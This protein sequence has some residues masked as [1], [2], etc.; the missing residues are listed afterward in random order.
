MTGHNGEIQILF[1]TFVHVTDIG[2]NKSEN[3]LCPSVV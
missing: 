2:Q 3:N 1:E